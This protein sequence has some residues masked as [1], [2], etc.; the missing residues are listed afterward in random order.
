MMNFIVL[1]ACTYSRFP[2]LHFEHALHLVN[3]GLHH[4]GAKTDVLFSLINYCAGPETQWLN[5]AGS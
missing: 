5:V 4:S 1:L 3:Q 2:P